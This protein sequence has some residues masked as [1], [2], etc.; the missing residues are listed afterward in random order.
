M[1]TD[2]TSTRLS[3]IAE[4]HAKAT[5]KLRHSNEEVGDVE[6]A[7]DDCGEERFC[8][9]ASFS[10]SCEDWANNSEF[11]VQAQSDIPFLLGHI[12]T[13]QAQAREDAAIMREALEPFAA[14]APEMRNSGEVIYG[15]GSI[16]CRASDFHKAR[17]AL[18]TDSETGG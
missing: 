13:L 3:E 18:N 5:P 6:G 8:H 11:F 1:T 17:T 10:G 2:P 4:R 16:N 15:V 14:I 12:A 9:V 7:F